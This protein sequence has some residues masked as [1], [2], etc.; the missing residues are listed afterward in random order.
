MQKLVFLYNQQCYLFIFFYVDECEAASECSLPDSD[1]C[2]DG[3]CVCGSAAGAAACNVGPVSGE[4]CKQG[5]C[6]CGAAPG[7]T[8]CP[9]GE[10]CKEGT[11]KSMYHN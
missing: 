9:S 2:I 5:T 8:A 1:N 6:V 7:A 3:E 10:Y 11:C 4:N